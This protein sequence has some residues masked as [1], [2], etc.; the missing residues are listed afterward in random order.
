MNKQCW[1][2]E[3][4][5]FEDY[6]N[7]WIEYEDVLYNEFK[8]DFIDS[9]P[10]YNNSLVRIKKYPLHDDKEEAFFHLTRKDCKEIGDRVPDF[11][12]CE[13]IR[14]IKAFIENYD[15]NG[16]ICENCD[17][18]K[19]WSEP[20]KNRQRIHFFFEE[21][22]YLVVIEKRDQYY[23]LITAFY[24]DYNHSLEKQIK[25]YERYSKNL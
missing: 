16:Y 4:L 6:N 5:Y 23:L 25:H 11:R 14:W 19:V 12:R 20:Y 1:I 21:E 8:K 13:R 2:P 3:L 17:G 24:L 15:C 10:Y 7:N 22:R 18:I 9:H